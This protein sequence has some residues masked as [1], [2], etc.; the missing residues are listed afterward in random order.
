MYADICPMEANV[1]ILRPPTKTTYPS[2]KGCETLS[3]VVDP[4]LVFKLSAF[5]FL[6]SDNKGAENTKSGLDFLRGKMI[7]SLPYACLGTQA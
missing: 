7:C 5:Y 2:R 6:A 1:M 3:E 4:H